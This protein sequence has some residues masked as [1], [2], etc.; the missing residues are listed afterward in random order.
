MR[1]PKGFYLKDFLKL[2]SAGGILLMIAAALAIILANSPLA[3]IYTSFINLPVSVKVGSFKIAKPLLLWINDGF[4]SLF[5]L[6]VGLELKREMLEGELST[7]ANIALP[8]FGAL[9]GMLVPAGI[10]VAFNINDPV[11]I[12]G[13]AIPTATDIAFALGILSLLGSRVPISLKI[14]LTSLAIFDDIGAVLII[15]IFYTANISF[16]ALA[17]VGICLLVLFY[18]NKRGFTEKMPYFAIGLIMWV[19]LLKSGVHATLA[20]VLLALFIPIRDAEGASPLRELEH[21]LHTIIAFGILPL[22]A[23]ANSGIVLLGV[24]P[25]A[26]FNSVSNGIIAGLFIGKQ[27]G[28]FIFCWIGVKLNVA[29]LPQQISWKALYGTAVLCGIGF[30][31]SLFIGSLAF[32]GPKPFD[33]RIGI[34]F[35]SLL[36]GVV[37]YSILSFSLKKAV[38]ATEISQSH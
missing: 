23:F 37:G 7:P 11:A 28:I 26:I 35:G 27:L 9:G 30:T 18:F 17:I 14:F 16:S 2:G 25:E 20:G 21:D 31:M 13:W 12:S 19:A 38:P 24:A 22:F 34:V 5:F 4:M 8:A 3:D 33:E 6:L 36:S 10:Y 1:K 32:T 29:R 15:A